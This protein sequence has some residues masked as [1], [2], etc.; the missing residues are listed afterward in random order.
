MTG[1]RGAGRIQVYVIVVGTLVIAGGGFL[2]LE[3]RFG[4][5][6]LLVEEGLEGGE[7]DLGGVRSPG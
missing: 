2:G 5:A 6:A 1:E 7:V 3:D 4:A